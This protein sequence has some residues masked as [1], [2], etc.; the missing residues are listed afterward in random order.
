[1][2]LYLLHCLFTMVHA[3]SKYCLSVHFA[4][5]R[6]NGKDMTDY[7]LSVNMKHEFAKPAVL[8]YPPAAQHDP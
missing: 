4:A 8:R 5:R 6:D 2:V 1:M 7:S 3:S